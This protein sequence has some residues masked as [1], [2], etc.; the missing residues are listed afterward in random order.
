ME[1][2]ALLGTH[3]T[4]KSTKAYSI[5]AN[6]KKNNID[7]EPLREI[8]RG[9]PLPINEQTTRTSQEW[10]IFN[11]YVK[12]IEESAYNIDVLVCDRSILDGYVY[13]YYKFG[14]NKLLEDFI[15]DKIKDYHS[16]WKMPL[17]GNYFTGLKNDGFRSIDVSFQKEIDECFKELLEKLE[18]EY[19]DF[20]S[21]EEVVESF[22]NGT[23]LQQFDLMKKEAE[24]YIGT[25]VVM[26]SWDGLLKLEDV[27]DHGDD[28]YWVCTDKRDNTKC[29]SCLMGFTPLKGHVN[30][31]D[32]QRM[33]QLWNNNS[34]NKVL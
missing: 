24:P 4:G 5:A 25:L 1:K 12:E 27:E 2:I 7:A 29:Q 34:E 20:V 22:K 8:I 13:Y 17:L 26:D 19:V 16:L 3:G 28:Y 9:C 23:I 31:G 18:I 15:K 32:Y 14:E 30:D 11:Q 21:E 6:L 10:N 33:K